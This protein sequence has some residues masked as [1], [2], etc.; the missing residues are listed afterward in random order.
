MPIMDGFEVAEQ[1][2]Q[3]E[4][5]ASIPVILFTGDARGTHEA[6]AQS[7]GIARVV[8]KP[9]IPFELMGIAQEIVNQSKSA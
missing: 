4:D 7:S 3:R 8:Y 9:M 5:L 1:L 2:R 6:K